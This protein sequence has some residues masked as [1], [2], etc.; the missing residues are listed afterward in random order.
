MIFVDSVK[1][2]RA[3]AIYL[4]TLLLD[5]LKDRGEDIIKSYLTILEATTKTDWLEKF[6]TGNTKIIIC[7][8]ATRI[9]VNILDI[10]HVIQ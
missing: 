1:K 9:R 6:L 8:N 4:Q 2:S 5:K 10:K 3:L 7:T